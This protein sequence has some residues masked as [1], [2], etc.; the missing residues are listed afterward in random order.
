MTKELREL[1]E[2]EDISSMSDA[3]FLYL[4]RKADEKVKR[5]KKQLNLKETK[6][7]MDLIGYS[8]YVSR[9]DIKEIQEILDIQGFYGLMTMVMVMKLCQA[10]GPEKITS[11]PD[12]QKKVT[13]MISNLE[14]NSPTLDRVIKTGLAQ[15][16]DY[17][18]NHP[19]KQG[20]NLNLFS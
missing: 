5:L 19:L 4:D 2:K 20:Q 18:K 12:G 11:D 16:A 13:E 1:R 7:L 15:V 17:Q 14:K 6:K 9:N 8:A 3:L 10:I